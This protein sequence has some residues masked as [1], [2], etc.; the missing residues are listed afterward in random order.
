MPQGH[1]VGVNDHEVFSTE[2]SEFFMRHDKG[3]TA[4]VILNGEKVAGWQRYTPQSVRRIV[5]VEVLQSYHCGA[6]GT[7]GVSNPIVWGV[8]L[9]RGTIDCDICRDERGIGHLG[10][11][12][13]YLISRPT[14]QLI[15]DKFKS[16]FAIQPILDSESR[17]GNKM[18]ELLNRLAVHDQRLF[19]G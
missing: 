7:Q 8:W 10:L 2:L 5:N 3:I 1:I 4:P 12:R 11:V 18:V 16:G 15:I 19:A 14:A 17:C 6:C 9:G 13:P